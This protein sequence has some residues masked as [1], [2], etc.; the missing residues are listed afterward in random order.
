[1]RL[2]SG[3]KKNSRK[4]QTP[5]REKHS[6]LLGFFST[7]STEA[8]RSSETSARLYQTTKRHISEDNRLHTVCLN[9]PI[10]IVSCSFYKKRGRGEAIND[11]T[12]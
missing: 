4:Q 7:L 1:M 8:V 12:R 5:G 10:S 6:C 11:V 2:C 3:M 9:K